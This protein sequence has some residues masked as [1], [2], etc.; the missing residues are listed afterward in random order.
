MH[1]TDVFS[2]GWVYNIGKTRRDRRKW[3]A[4]LKTVTPNLIRTVKTSLPPFKK[5]F[6]D[7]C[8]EW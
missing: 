3:I 7:Q 4:F 2:C 8:Y 6:V 5:I 1:S